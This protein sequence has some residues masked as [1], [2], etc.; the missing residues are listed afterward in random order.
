MIDDTWWLEDGGVLMLWRYYV[1][2]DKRML[3]VEGPDHDDM[4]VPFAEVDAQ[5]MASCQAAHEAARLE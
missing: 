1:D 5:W 2:W 3:R 4:S